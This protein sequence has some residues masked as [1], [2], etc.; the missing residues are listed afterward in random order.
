MTVTET[1][2]K[3]TQFRRVALLICFASY[4]NPRIVLLGRRR[5]GR[6][7]QKTNDER[8]SVIVIGREINPI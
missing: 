3:L 1:G 5:E 4:T 8:G 2:E 6:L 7:K